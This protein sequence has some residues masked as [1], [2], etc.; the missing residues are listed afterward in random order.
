MQENDNIAENP[1]KDIMVNVGSAT[2][3]KNG[4][5]AMQVIQGKQQLI[6]ID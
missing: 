4:S 5:G 6:N 3:D 1:K 2:Y